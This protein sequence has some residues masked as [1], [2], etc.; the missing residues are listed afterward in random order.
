MDDLK[1]AAQNGDLNMLYYLIYN[2]PSLLDHIDE[3]TFFDT[4]LHI[5]AQYGKVEFAKEIM[6]LK[7]SFARMLNQSLYSPMHLALYNK[8][9]NMVHLFL[10]CE[11]PDRLVRIR[12]RHGETPLHYLAAKENDVDHQQQ[13][14]L[15]LPKFISVCP[16]SIQDTNNRKETA[17]HLAVK[18]ENDDAFDFLLGGLRRACHKGSEMDER[19]I[20]NLKD[21][22]GDN[23]LHIATAM[24]QSQLMDLT[25]S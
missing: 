13:K 12:G 7:P 5:A 11:A 3:V 16:Q 15:L 21:A 22:N 19:K 14:I 9:I 8:Q 18:S 4:P 23:V 20:I 6:N 25:V 2:N 1:T 17:F 10:E 24:N